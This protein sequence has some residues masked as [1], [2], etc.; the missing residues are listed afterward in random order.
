MVDV[1]PMG[2]RIGDLL[3]DR[4][5]LTQEIGEGGMG[6]V[7]R[8]HDRMLDRDVAIKVLARATSHGMDV[9]FQRA[10]F[11]QARAAARLT[12]PGVITIFDVGHQDDRVFIVM[13]LVEGPTLQQVLRR[14]GLLPLDRAVT[15]AADLADVLDHAHRLGV[16]H[17]DVRP[18]N[19]VLAEGGMPRL[20]DFAIAS[21]ATTTGAF[22]PDQL[23]GSVPYLA[24]EQLRGEQV[25]ARADIYSLGVVLYEMLTGRPPFEGDDVG[26]VAQAR[27]AQDPPPPGA[28]NPSIPPKLERIVLKALARDPR[29]RYPSAAELRDNLRALAPALAVAHAQTMRIDG[30]D[31]EQLRKGRT[32]PPPPSRGDSL[33]RPAGVGRSRLLINVLIFLA[34][35]CLLVGGLMYAASL[36]RPQEPAEAWATFTA[37]SCQWSNTTT[38]PAICFGERDPGY[39]VRIVSR[40]GDRWLVWDPATS[41]VAY[42]DANALKE[43]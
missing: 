18:D 23:R 12:H 19:V 17:G 11:E 7:F 5:E 21:A 40:E 37:R 6:R 31:L 38:P 14:E 30:R 26:A 42:V 24:P 36:T 35:V 8:A 3:I 28:F 2:P 20:V 33:S 41:N 32:R 10:C 4:Y 1:A 15:I 13:E 16:L 9:A 27:L 39:R 22:G 43:E 34:V 29:E 25:D